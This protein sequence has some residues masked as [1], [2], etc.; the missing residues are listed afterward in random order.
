[1]TD[2]LSAWHARARS[3]RDGLLPLHFLV[4][5]FE[6]HGADS[7]QPVRAEATGTL[8]LDGSWLE[9]RERLLGTEGELL[10]DDFVLYRYDPA[11]EGLRVLHF[12]ERAWHSQ[13]PVHLAPDGAIHW[14]TGV[15]GPRVHIQASPTGWGSQVTL[16]DEDTPTVVLEYQRVGADEPGV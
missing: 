16:P 8:V 11:E 1:M 3:C 7:G 6:G 9:L 2:D 13:Y 10:Y 12:M 14:T 15:G 4:G 5:R